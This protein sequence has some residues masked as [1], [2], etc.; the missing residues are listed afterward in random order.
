MARGL[1]RSMADAVFPRASHAAQLSAVGGY[2]STF[3][4]YSPRFTTWAGGLYEAELTRS[5]I[6][7]G[8]N[9]AS[10]LRPEVSGVAK[11]RATRSLRFQPNPWQT[12]PQFISR[13]WRM[14]QVNDTCLIVPLLAEDG[15]TQVGYW[16]ALPGAC[17]A[18][19]VDGS[20]WLRLDFPTGEPQYVEWS[21][22]GVL[23]RHQYQSD[24]FGDGTDV[25]GPTLEL[26]HAQVE[27]ERNAIAQGAQ[28]R[29]IGKLAQNLDPKDAKE[30][31]RQFNAQ[32]LSADNAGGLAV[33]DRMFDEVKQ[34]TPQS[35]TVDAAQMER[36]EKA[37]YRHFGVCEDVVLNRADEDTFNAFYE[38]AVE[39]FAVQLGNVL[40]CMTFSPYEISC[41]NE[42][43]LSA[44][45]LEYASNATKLKVAT[46]AFDRGALTGNQFADIF[47]WPHYE[48]GD[49]HVIRGEFIDLSLISE[50][51][52]QAAAQAAQVNADVAAAFGQAE[53]G[54]GG[55][56]AG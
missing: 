15:V 9:H 7:A 27:A 56:D 48:G 23:T 28:V 38:G 21:R 18:W 25:L 36:I 19:D 44:N 37:V 49:R 30:K 32:N 14:L 17:E 5:A 31:Q 45:R 43:M 41:G 3:T 47:Q 13:V 34:V 55:T 22:V 1:L 12:T 40:T 46:A 35:Y 20:L 2:F 54:E 16:P 6:E 52:A 24:L 4:A 39:P 26:L 53:D 8:A 29:F 51:T 33:Y 10:K 50:H 42:I 11:P